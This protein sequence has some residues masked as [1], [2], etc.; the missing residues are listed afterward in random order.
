[1]PACPPLAAAMS[2]G[3]GSSSRPSGETP[4]VSMAATM[5]CRPMRTA[6]RS[7]EFPRRSARLPLAPAASNRRTTLSAGT[8][9][10]EASL[11]VTV[12]PTVIMK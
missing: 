11:F 5:S 7:A 1:M 4:C 3:S 6:S 9:A 2:G 8:V 12:S 10:V